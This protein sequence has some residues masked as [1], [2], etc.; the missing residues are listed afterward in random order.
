MTML[1]YIKLRIIG[2]LTTV[3]FLANPEHQIAFI[4]ACFGIAGGG[5]YQCLT[6]DSRKPTWKFVLGDL[7]CSAFLGFASYVTTGAEPLKAILLAVP[8]GF[9]ASAS[10]AQ[11]VKKYKPSWLEEEK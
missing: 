10:F 1:G 4:M 2:A 3:V 8:A 7:G 5:I 11:Y 9:G 6:F